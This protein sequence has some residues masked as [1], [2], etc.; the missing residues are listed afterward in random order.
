LSRMMTLIS[1]TAIILGIGA[2]VAAC[3]A[4]PP[5]PQ[6]LAEAGVEPAPPEYI[7]GPLD[8]VQIYVA[9]APELSVTVPVRPDGRISTP[10]V[11]DMLAA[12]KTPAQLSRDVQSALLPYVQDPEVSVVMQ[13]FADTSAY[14]VR[15][16]GAVANPRPVPF[17]PYMTVLDAM[18]AAGGLGE[19]AAG[20]RAVLIR[21]HQGGREEVYR[22][23]LQDLLTDADLSANAPVLPGDVIIVPESLL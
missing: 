1:Q 22:L 14:T 11:A 3:G 15:V 20:N 21:G 6:Q 2:V 17:R 10:L 5:P 13:E 18:I 4:P 9:G 12:G 23:R 16:M 7:I 8:Q 19:F